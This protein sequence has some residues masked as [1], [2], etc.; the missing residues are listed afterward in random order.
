MPCEVGDQ[1]TERRLSATIRS[2]ISRYADAYRPK[3]VVASGVKCGGD[4]VHEHRQHGTGEPHR[5]ERFTM[6][7]LANLYRVRHRLLP[8]GR[9]ACLA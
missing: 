4:R 6:F 1:R 3:R 7:G 8:R 9:T 5:Y 2:S